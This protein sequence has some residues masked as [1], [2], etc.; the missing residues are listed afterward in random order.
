[1]WVG[2]RSAPPGGGDATLT[3]SAGGGTLEDGWPTHR[4][5]FLERLFMAKA[6]VGQLGG[7]SRASVRLETENRRLRARV[8]D[9]EALVLSLQAENDRLAAA[10]RDEVAADS[11]MLPA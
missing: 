11:R 9:L 5:P 7:A 1:M 10:V 6:L 4:Q 8:R 2:H 3:R